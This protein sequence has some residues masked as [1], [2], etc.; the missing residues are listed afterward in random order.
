MKII[1]AE[2]AAKLLGEATP[3]PWGAA[4]L[5][6]Q[7]G[8]EWRVT[9]VQRAIDM[10][11]GKRSDAFLMA[12]APDLAHTV[13]HLWARLA[14]VERER[15]ADL[16]RMQNVVYDALVSGVKSSIPGADIGRIDGAG[17]DSDE[18]DFTAAE[19]SIALS[20][21]DD[22]IERVKQERDEA[23]AQLAACASAPNAYHPDPELNAA[24]AREATEAAAFDMAAGIDPGWHRGN[25]GAEVAQ[26]RAQLADLRVSF[27][28]DVVAHAG[29][30]AQETAK[31]AIDAL[32]RA[33]YPDSAALLRGVFRAP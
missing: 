23:R 29:L 33:D 9:P 18:F 10:V 4:Y 16:G 15:D 27:D 32:E 14:E 12:S 24:V 2:E 25:P 20:M 19:V 5:I 7:D 17:S 3:G 13:T 26:L 21:M 31:R 22:E 8:T 28:R 6:R 1:T 30:A 11:I